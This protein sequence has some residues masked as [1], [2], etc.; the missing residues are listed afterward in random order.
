MET[1]KKVKYL[2]ICWLGYSA[3]EKKWVRRVVAEWGTMWKECSFQI[4]KS[5]EASKVMVT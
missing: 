4:G 5:G 2:I 3:V 1:D